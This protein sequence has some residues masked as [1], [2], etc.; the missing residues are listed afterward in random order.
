MRARFLKTVEIA[1]N[2]QITDT[3][4]DTLEFDTLKGLSPSMVHVSARAPSSRG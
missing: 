4:I 2:G 1:D 3:V